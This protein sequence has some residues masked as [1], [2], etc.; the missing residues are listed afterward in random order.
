[1]SAFGGDPGSEGEVGA[2]LDLT[3][4]VDAAALEAL[5]EYLMS[6]GVDQGREGF[7]REEGS[8]A[9]EA[10]GIGKREYGD[11]EGDYGEMVEL[12]DRDTSTWCGDVFVAYSGS[13]DTKQDR[14]HR[15][16]PRTWRPNANAARLPGVLSFARAL[17]FFEKIGKL[18]VI[19]S[20]PQAVP[21]E[22][23]DHSCAP[24]S[25]HTSLPQTPRLTQQ[26]RRDELRIAQ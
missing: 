15:C 25:P 23:A 19:R 24:P 20:A 1:M 14:G 3:S 11:A 6:K 5:D 13:D 18:C 4:F 2:F 17:P 9:L 26:P 22:H 7:A 12:C 10:W 16:D 21:K 8:A